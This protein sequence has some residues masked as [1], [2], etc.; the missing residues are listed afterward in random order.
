M[1]G[2]ATRKEERV[3]EQEPLGYLP[4]HLPTCL[5]LYG[6]GGGV[7]LVD[8]ARDKDKTRILAEI[9][10][11]HLNRGLYRSLYP[12][13]SYI[14]RSTI[15]NRQPALIRQLKRNRGRPRHMPF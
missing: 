6:R 14:T 13:L 5:P 3:A 12:I 1:H 7:G 11:I 9:Y 8:S 15:D 4:L 10:R 2:P